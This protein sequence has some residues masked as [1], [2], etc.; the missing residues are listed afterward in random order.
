[1]WYNIAIPKAEYDKLTAEQK[2]DY[3]P[4]RDR[5]VRTLFNIE[6]TTLPLSDPKAFEKAVKEEGH[7]AERETEAD[8]KRTRIEVN[9]LLNKLSENLVPIRKDGTGLAHYDS[10][11]DIVHLPA[12]EQ[13]KKTR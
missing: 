5:Q 2:Q 6:Q 12:Q 10:A 3:A 7:S 9:L 11:K 8:D 13:F 1:M 4:V